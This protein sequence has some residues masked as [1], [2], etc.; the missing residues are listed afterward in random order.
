MIVGVIVVAVLAAWALSYARAPPIATF[1][2]SVGEADSS[3][4]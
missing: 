3:R 2:R 1:D 4:L